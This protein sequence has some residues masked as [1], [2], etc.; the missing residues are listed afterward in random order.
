MIEERKGLG[1]TE[2]RIS[3]EPWQQC[4]SASPIR[5]IAATKRHRSAI[6]SSSTVL[7]LHEEAAVP[8]LPP[9]PD[10]VTLN[11]TEHAER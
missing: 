4:G 6:S 10:T 8:H 3:L 7:Q 11:L 5:R 2:F 1:S 9:F